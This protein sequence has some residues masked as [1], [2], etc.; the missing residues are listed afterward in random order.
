[1]KLSEYFDSSEFTQSDIAQAR[2][3]TNEPSKKALEALQAL[4]TNTLQPARQIL[5]FP[6]HISSGY[7]SKELNEAIGAAKESQHTKGEAADIVSRDNTR[8]FNFIAEHCNYDQLIWE[9]GDNQQPDW[10]HVSYRKGANRRERLRAVK[11]NG[12]TKYKPF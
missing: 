4:V 11:V 9:F 7:R 6:I 5:G 3:I 1:M 10:V 8:V 2:G 12:V